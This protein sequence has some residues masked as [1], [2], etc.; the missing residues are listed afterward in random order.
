MIEKLTNPVEQ[1]IRNYFNYN[2]KLDNLMIQLEKKRFEGSPKDI[3]A[4]DYESISSGTS[5]RQSAERVLSDV[6]KL[7]KQ[8]NDLKME[9]KIVG[10]TLNIMKVDNPTEYNFVMEYYKKGKDIMAVAVDLGYSYNSRNSIYK[11]KENTL[12]I[13]K[14]FGL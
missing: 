5:K 12:K 7:Q 10:S 13:F 3:G 2:A 1:K 9:F 6:Q 14:E 11:I 4:I 8:I